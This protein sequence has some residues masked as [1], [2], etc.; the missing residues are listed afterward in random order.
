M[1][2]EIL[3]ILKCPVCGR[4][5]KL[6][7]FEM[8][9][10]EI[11]NGNLI[12]DDGHKWFIHEGVLDFNSKEQEVGN[13]WT[14]MAAE[15]GFDEMD[16]IITEKIPQNMKDIYSAAINTVVQYINRKKPE[17]VL[18]I[19]SG[20]GMLLKELSRNIDSDTQI[21][22]VDLSYSILREDR[23]K[24]RTINENAKINY[25]ACD[26][27]NLPLKDNTIDSAVS[28]FGLS[29]M[30]NL[31]P[32]GIKEAAR[33]LKD[34]QRLLSAEI[35]IKEDSQG[36]KTL[37][38]FAAENKIN[39]H[40]KYATMEGL[41]YSYINDIFKSFVIEIVSEGIGEKNELDLL[42]YENEWFAVVIVQCDK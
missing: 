25:I 23:E 20:R 34:G 2:Y 1:H 31:M 11:Y 17:Y 38:N 8:K 9:E 6:D 16:T 18:D 26:A 28:F 4:E 21:I 36:Y 19:A 39:L 41:K 7:K 12:C 27:S 37:M 22:S 33:V 14:E 3:N 24:I 35:L 13:R 5:L 29:N 30:L 42:P 15:T 10:N 40:E 32:K